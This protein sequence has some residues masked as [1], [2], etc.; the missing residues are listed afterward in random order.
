M[1]IEI[2]RRLF[3]AIEQGELAAIEAAYHEDAEQVEHPNR[4]LPGGARR[5]RAALV[6][7]ARRGKALLATQRLVIDNSVANGDRLA[8]EAS[9][10][11]TLAVDAPPL[12]LKAGDGMQA[13]F[14]QFFQFRDG[15]ILRHHTYDCFSPWGD[16]QP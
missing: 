12:G 6:E 1:S 11:A 10:S 8:L 9:W 2:V 14:A 5:D 3:A 16:S 13:R 15:R 4:L 7:A